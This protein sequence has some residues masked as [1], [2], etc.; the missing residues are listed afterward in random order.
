MKASE[1]IRATKELLME[2]GWVQGDFVIFKCYDDD[3]IFVRDNKVVGYCMYG[4]LGKV[5]F[6]DAE[7]YNSSYGE[8][9][10]TAQHIIAAIPTGQG[11]VNFNDFPGRQFDEVCDVLDRAEKFALIAEEAEL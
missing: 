10:R 6:D 1:E 9:N 5:Q 8:S 2:E 11:I 4:A 3:D 7:Y